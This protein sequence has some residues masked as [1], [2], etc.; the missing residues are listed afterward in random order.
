MTAR[1]I[2]E[3]GPARLPIGR[4]GNGLARRVDLAD[5]GQ[6][7][8][9]VIDVIRRQAGLNDLGRPAEGRVPGVGGRHG[10]CRARISRDLPNGL[11]KLWSRLNN[12]AIF[13]IYVESRFK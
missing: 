2:G 1:V 10:A 5:R 12:Y 6:L 11:G 9:C 7:A 3:A 13:Q 4:I 8:L